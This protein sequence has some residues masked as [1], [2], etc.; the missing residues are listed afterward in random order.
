MR[1]LHLTTTGWHPR[2]GVARSVQALASRLPG[3]HHL[4]APGACGTVFAGVHD[5]DIGVVPRPRV[6]ALGDLLDRLRPDVVH[7]HG[8]EGVAAAVW[9]LGPSA[10]P[11][12]ASVYG[13]LDPPGPRQLAAGVLAVRDHR[14]TAMSLSRRLVTA[15]AGLPLLAR[16]LRRGTIAA[17]CSTDVEVVAR[18]AAAGPTYL[19]RGAADPSTRRAD[20]S[21][22]PTLVFAGRAEHA[23][24]L[25]DLVLAFLRIR[26]AVPAARLRLALLP[27]PAAPRWARLRLPGIDA[28]VGVVDDLGGTLAG[29]QLAV[30]PFRVDATITPALVAAEAM[31]HGLPVVGTDVRCL[32]ALVLDGV[33]GR[34]VPRRRPAALADACV[35]MLTDRDGWHGRAERAHRTIEDTWSWDHA[36]AAVAAAHDI[37]TGRPAVGLPRRPTVR[38]L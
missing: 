14:S 5:V 30:L 37:A 31:A 7:L 22:A 35:E 17:V 8:G 3:E 6:P 4:A 2:E 25:D 33:N 20:W 38:P 11:V 27:A 21:D 36:A 19:A 18:L 10:P 28:T 15:S 13:R 32:R 24:G 9:A 34:I 23:R 12:V 26:R 16:C 29:A 1:V